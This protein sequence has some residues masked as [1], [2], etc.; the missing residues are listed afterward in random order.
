MVIF[1]WV[2][3]AIYLLIGVCCGLLATALLGGGIPATVTLTP[4]WKL[5]FSLIFLGTVLFW[6]PALIIINIP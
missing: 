3:L 2:C 4:I 1:L 5:K 6:L